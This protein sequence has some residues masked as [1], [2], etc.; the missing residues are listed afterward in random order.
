MLFDIL[1]NIFG[2]IFIIGV[3]VCLV[4][5]ALAIF[6]MVIAFFSKDPN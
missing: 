3:L 4:L 5:A 2:V 1:V 6:S